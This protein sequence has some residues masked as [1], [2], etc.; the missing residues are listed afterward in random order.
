MKRSLHPESFRLTLDVTTKRSSSLYPPGNERS[1]FCNQGEESISS[2]VAVI[3]FVFNFEKK[4]VEIERKGEML[5]NLSI[6]SI[7]WLSHDNQSD[8]D[9]MNKSGFT[10]G[11]LKSQNISDILF[12]ESAGGFFSLHFKVNI[13]HSYEVGLYTLTFHNCDKDSKEVNFTVYLEEKNENNYLSVGDIPLP[14]LYFSLFTIYLA[15]GT[16]WLIVLRKSREEVFKIHYLML[17]LMYIKSVSLLFHGIN[18][19]FIEVRGEQEEA[20]AILFYIIYLMKG[21]LMFVT[22]ILIG[23]GWTFIKHILSEKEKKVFAVVIPLQILTNVAHI[24]MFE[25]EEGQ[26]SYNIWYNIFILVDLVCC[27]AILFPVVWSIRHLQQ[28]STVIG[29]AAMNLKKL[30]IF[31]HFYVMVVFYIYFTRVIVLLLNYIIPFQYTWLDELLVELATLSFFITTGYKFRPASNNPYLL[32]SQ[33][34]DEPEVEILT[35]SGAFESITKV[36]Y[37]PKKILTEP[38]KPI[39]QDELQDLD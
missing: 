38:E 28:A 27:G 4:L 23:A 33:S 20:F 34:D 29:K 31:R 13:N 22:I 2:D 37:K 11:D 25:T 12:L 6:S 35:K 39:L 15:L 10:I 32:V 1:D 30:K 3:I 21:I 18:Y 19:R 8:L 36:N 24:I 16:L 17:S 7:Q 26:T 14:I 5:Q 9:F